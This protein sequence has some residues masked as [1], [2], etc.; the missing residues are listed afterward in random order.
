[1]KK[2]VFEGIKEKVKG[3]NS[4]Q[5]HLRGFLAGQSAPGL[6]TALPSSSSGFK[7]AFESYLI[8]DP[9]QTLQPKYEL[10]KLNEQRLEIFEKKEEVIMR[11]IL[12]R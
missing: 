4:E 5:L 9:I 7:E 11:K 8:S 3:M 12:L 2:V 1:M 10:S 6:K